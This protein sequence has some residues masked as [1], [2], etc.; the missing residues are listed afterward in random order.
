MSYK[1]FWSPRVFDGQRFISNGLL[2]INETGEVIDLVEEA[3]PEDAY[4]TNNIISPGFINAHCHL[5]LSHMKGKIGEGTGLADFVLAVV[6]ERTAERPLIE[7]AIQTAMEELW[8]GGTSGVGDICNIDIT[9]SLKR[10]S[11][12]AFHNFI[13][14]SGWLPEVAQARYERAQELLAQFGPA[15]SSIVPHAPYSVSNN[16]WALLQPGFKNNITSIHNAETPTEDEFFMTGGGVFPSMY[17]KMGMN[18]V[19]HKPT[20]TSGLASYYNR[21]GEAR[22]L[23]LVHNTF[24]KEAD[25]DA[26]MQGGPPTFFCICIRANRYIENALPPVDLLYKKGCSI[27]IGTDSLASNWSLSVIDEIQSIHQSFPSIPIDQLL[28]WATAN[29]AQALGFDQLGS[30]A[31]GKL[32]G[33][34]EIDPALQWAHRLS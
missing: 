20:G 13:E 9:A 30:F 23:L 28:K 24:L 26:V 5:E 4:Q 27:L 3:S 32:P 11:H 17:E 33:V 29:G 18:A 25:M 15:H 6:K 22:S 19:H 12:M 16:L 31:K 21:F 34:I 2:I 10:D 7:S 8:K 14:V 1:K